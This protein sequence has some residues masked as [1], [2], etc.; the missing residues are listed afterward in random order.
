MMSIFDSIMQL[1]KPRKDPGFT[2]F[3]TVTGVVIMAIAFGP[4]LFFLFCKLFEIMEHTGRRNNH[5]DFD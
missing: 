2:F 4:G 1:C 5:R 3:G